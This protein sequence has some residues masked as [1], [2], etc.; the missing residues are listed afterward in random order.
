M[1]GAWIGS[2]LRNSY[3]SFAVSPGERHLC[4]NWQSSDRH[5]SSQYSATGFTAEAGKIS[6]FRTHV[7]Y[8]T[9]IARIDL[10]P[11]NSDERQYQVNSFALV[12]FHPKT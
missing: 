7:L 9:A 8:S 6:Y 10:D 5:Q 11:I 4:A 3:F 2:N 1:D 12:E